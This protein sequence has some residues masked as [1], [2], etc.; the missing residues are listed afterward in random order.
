M[1]LDLGALSSL[2]GLVS[3]I[4]S[5]GIVYGVMKEKLKTV[6]SELSSLKNQYDAERKAINDGY[7]ALGHFKDV[8]TPIQS[9][10]NEVQNDVKKLLL[11]AGSGSQK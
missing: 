11:I 8:V 3:S 1:S 10:I 7:V 6:E 9:A 5:A 2:V 4:L